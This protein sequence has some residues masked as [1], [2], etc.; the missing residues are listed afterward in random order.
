VL[1]DFKWLPSSE[2]SVM[3][4]LLARLR[5]ALRTQQET[6]ERRF[7]AFVRRRRIRAQF[8][9]IFVNQVEKLDSSL[10]WFR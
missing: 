7:S 10:N 3:T 5:K 4:Q 1:R 6:A 8:M 9:P 2:M